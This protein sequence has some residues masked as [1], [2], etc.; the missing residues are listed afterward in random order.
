MSRGRSPISSRN[1]VPPAADRIETLLIGDRAGEASSP[2]AEQL[3]IG[4]LARRCGAAYGQG[5]AH[6]RRAV[7]DRPRHGPSRCRFRP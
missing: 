1:S 4:Q 6:A 7:M 5:I 3:A 2:M